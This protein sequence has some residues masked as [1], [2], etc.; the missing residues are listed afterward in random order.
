MNKTRWKIRLENCKIMPVMG[1]YLS[2]DIALR[3]WQILFS[4][5]TGYHFTSICNHQKKP[6]RV[7]YTLQGQPEDRFSNLHHYQLNY[8][9]ISQLSDNKGFKFDISTFDWNTFLQTFIAQYIVHGYPSE[10]IQSQKNLS[11]HTH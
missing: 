3:N 11:S 2:F 9:S 1:V 5:V 8:E 4:L 7:A 10:Y 6:G